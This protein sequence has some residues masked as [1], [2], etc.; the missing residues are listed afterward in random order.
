MTAFLTHTKSGQSR[1]RRIIVAQDLQQPIN[2]LAPSSSPAA[3]ARLKFLQQPPA[4]LAHWQKAPGGRR[5][6]SLACVAPRLASNRLALES[7]GRRCLKGCRATTRQLTATR[8]G[9]ELSR[10]Q[11]AVPPHPRP[12]AGS[13]TVSHTQQHTVPSRLTGMKRTRST[14]YPPSSRP[15]VGL[16][17]HPEEV[18][19]GPASLKMLRVLQAFFAR[20]PLCASFRRVLSDDCALLAVHQQ[21]AHS[22][23]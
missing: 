2:K 5:R 18:K 14:I 15:S 9:A 21:Q 23:Y 4:L 12:P 22:S 11:A 7:L 6:S 16:S 19:Q 1:T 3:A 20:V 10:T 8:A 13:L 17:S